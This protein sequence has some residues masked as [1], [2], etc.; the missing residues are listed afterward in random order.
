VDNM[1]DMKRPTSVTVT[2]ELTVRR[3]LRDRPP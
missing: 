3:T 1:A 2:D